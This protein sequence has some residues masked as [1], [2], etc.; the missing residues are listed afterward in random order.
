MPK[1]ASSLTDLLEICGHELEAGAS[2]SCFNALCVGAR[3]VGRWIYPAWRCEGRTDGH[4]TG[5]ADVRNR[6]GVM[7]GSK[8][9]K[10]A[11]RL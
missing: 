5:A 8:Q 3:E 6:V 10:R 1:D 11:V 4:R 2:Q 7:I 9:V